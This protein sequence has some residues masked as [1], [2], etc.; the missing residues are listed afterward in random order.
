MTFPAGAIDV[1]VEPAGEIVRRFRGA[2]EAASDARYG[3]DN[4]GETA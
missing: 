4:R 2:A 3:R 1:Q